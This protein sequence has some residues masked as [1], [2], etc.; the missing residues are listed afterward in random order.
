[1]VNGF[2]IVKHLTLPYLSIDINTY[3]IHM[4]I[5]Y[6]AVCM[7]TCRNERIQG[8]LQRLVSGDEEEGPSPAVDDAGHLQIAIPLS[9]LETRTEQQLLL[10]IGRYI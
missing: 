2:T 1:M 9:K 8:K 6:I 4:A 5:V 10:V 3:I 7:K